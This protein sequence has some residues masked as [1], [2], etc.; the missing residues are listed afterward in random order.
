MSLILTTCLMSDSG[1]FPGGKGMKLKYVVGTS[2]V[3]IAG[4]LILVL[5]RDDASVIG[6]FIKFIGLCLTLISAFLLIC[7]FFGITLNRLE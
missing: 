3:L 4:I 6:G 5:V 7:S 2:V 1:A